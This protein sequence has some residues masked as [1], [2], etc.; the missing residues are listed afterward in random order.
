MKDHQASDDLTNLID[1]NWH[2]LAVVVFNWDFKRVIR[3]FRDGKYVSEKILLDNYGTMDNSAP[4][5]MG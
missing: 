1:G 3:Y 2:S 4:L 5:Q